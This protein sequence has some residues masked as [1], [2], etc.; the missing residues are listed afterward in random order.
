MHNVIYNLPIM[1]S[2]HG[3]KLRQNKKPTMSPPW[4]IKSYW[5]LVGCLDPED[6]LNARNIKWITR[7]LCCSTSHGSCL[8]T[9]CMARLQAGQPSRSEPQRLFTLQAWC[10]WMKISHE[11]QKGSP[12]PHGKCLAFSGMGITFSFSFLRL[13]LKV[14]L[15]KWKWILFFVKKKKK[16]RNIDA[17]HCQT[18]S[19]L[20]CRSPEWLIL[21]GGF[22]VTSISVPF[23]CINLYVCVF[24][25]LFEESQLSAAVNMF[26]TV[27]NEGRK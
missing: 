26:L 7:L 24:F 25:L 1:K 16:E 12:L 10:V 19:F 18:L 22:A 8:Q 5:L 15:E 21:W 23:I 14:M 27:S 6:L 17:G 9:Q 2:G 3:V 20:A 11:G 13:T 4:C